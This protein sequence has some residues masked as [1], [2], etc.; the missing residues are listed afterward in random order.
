MKNICKTILYILGI[1]SGIRILS[2]EIS[3]K[4]TSSSLIQY[5]NVIKSFEIIR[6]WLVRFIIFMSRNFVFYE[7]IREV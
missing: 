6:I 3:L 1:T 7:L 4:F 5:H 2:G